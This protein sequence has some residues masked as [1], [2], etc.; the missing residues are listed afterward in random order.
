MNQLAGVELRDWIRAGSRPVKICPPDPIAGY[1]LVTLEDGTI[2]K[3]PIRTSARIISIEFVSEF[4]SCP[5]D[6]EN[7]DDDGVFA[8]RAR[9]SDIE[10]VQSNLGR[11]DAQHSMSELI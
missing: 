2:Q 8:T 6:Y 5:W 9:L 7:P 4:H 1:M 3:R 11:L 10:A